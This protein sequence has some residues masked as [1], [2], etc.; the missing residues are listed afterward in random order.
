MYITDLCT[1]IGR[2]YVLYKR[3]VTFNRCSKK[4]ERMSTSD[5]WSYIFPCNY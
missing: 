3:E 4:L 5:L 1:T 2:T